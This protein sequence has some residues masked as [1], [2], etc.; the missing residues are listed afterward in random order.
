MGESLW[1]DSLIKAS[2]TRQPVRDNRDGQSLIAVP[3]V[4]GNEVIGAI[5]VESGDR[6]ADAEAIQMVQAVAQRLAISLDK[7]RL[8]EESQEATSREQRINEI[9]SRYQTVTNVDE[10]LRITL[11]ELTQTLGAKHS[12]IRLG[13]I[14]A[15]PLNGNGERRA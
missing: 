3:L 4:L 8:F 7:A 11:E 9:V 2:Q 12:A 1:T 10:L 15:A 13:A 5:E 14:P 6:K